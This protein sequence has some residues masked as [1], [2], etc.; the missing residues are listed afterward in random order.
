MLMN[1]VYSCFLLL[2]FCCYPLYGDEPAKTGTLIVSYQTGLNGERLD[3]VRFF[4]SSK[5]FCQNMYPKKGAYV[6]DVAGLMRLVVIEDL[7][8]G[9]YQLEF[10][11]PNADGI[12]DEVPL[13]AVEIV[14][15]ETLKIDQVISP[16]Y[17]N[18][19]ATFQLQ[20]ETSTSHPTPTI[21][22]KNDS[23]NVCAQSYKG[24]LR[25][26]HLLPGEYMLIFGQLSGYN[27]PSPIPVTLLPGE[28]K[29]NLVGTYRSQ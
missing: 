19:Q 27:A 20:G 11:V 14:A 25:A 10:I 6:D 9:T 13:K 22:L 29:D 15:G 8:P 5:E 4:L 21:L 23:G 28:Q 12:F 7:S 3:R 26:T 17:A 16:R 18:L 2:S 1:K 24:I